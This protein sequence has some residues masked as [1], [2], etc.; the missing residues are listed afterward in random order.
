MTMLRRLCTQEREIEGV[1][2]QF[3]SS[4]LKNEL[5]LCA[6]SPLSNNPAMKLLNA[7]KQSAAAGERSV[8]WGLWAAGAVPREMWSRMWDVTRQRLLECPAHR[9]SKLKQRPTVISYLRL[10]HFVPQHCQIGRY[11]QRLSE[12]KPQYPHFMAGGELP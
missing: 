9:Q 2:V 7:C 12:R 3:P 11:L 4:S 8:V 6:R 1:C 10:W 5:L